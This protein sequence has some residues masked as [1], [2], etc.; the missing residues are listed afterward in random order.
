M[1]AQAASALSK[2]ELNIR[3]CPVCIRYSSVAFISLLMSF[4]YHVSVATQPRTVTRS[5]STIYYRCVATSQPPQVTYHDLATKLA[6]VYWFSPNEPLFDDTMALPSAL[7]VPEH[8]YAVA[9]DGIV[10][11]RVVHVRTTVASSYRRDTVRYEKPPGI[12]GHN[13]P[14]RR[15]SEVTIRYYT[16]YMKDIGSTGHVH[17][18]EVVD[19]VLEI[20]VQDR[21]P[22]SCYEVRLARIIGA[23]HGADWYANI[24]DVDVGAT[25]D[26]VLP[27]HILVEEGKHAN[28][29]DRNADGWFTRGYDVTRQV[30]EA[31]GVRDALRNDRVPTGRY[32]ASHAKDRCSDPQ[33]AVLK[34]RLALITDVDARGGRRWSGWGGSRCLSSLSK[35]QISNQ[36]TTYQ[37]YE[38]GVGVTGGLCTHGD[39]GLL[40][41]GKELYKYL[42]KWRFCEPTLV[43]LPV[44][45]VGRRIS[46]IAGPTHHRTRHHVTRWNWGYG[47]YFGGGPTYGRAVVAPVAWEVPFVGGWHMPRLSVGRAEGSVDWLYTTSAAGVTDFY[48]QVGRDCRR[49]RSSTIDA[50]C[51]WETVQEFGIKFHLP[52]SDDWRRLFRVGVGLRGPMVGKTPRANFMV[53]VGVG[54][55]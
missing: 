49:G 45:R 36:L 35:T 13:V 34:E 38:A 3:G 19:V 23:A 48:F 29:P 11:Y 52:L 41:R 21:R 37:L 20:N 5:P 14:L 12:G 10:Y 28:A 30:N 50:Q 6:P 9:P 27:P 42:K 17:D 26:L 39:N 44:D 2:K 8:D 40:R 31:W 1:F 7:P 46:S 51:E 25:D 18:L 33:M 24:L 53:E 54:G 16:Y 22:K 47:Y 32:D 43:G 4:G 15:L 55:W